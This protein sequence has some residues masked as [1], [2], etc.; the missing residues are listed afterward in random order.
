MSY[1]L[2]KYLCEYYLKYSVTDASPETSDIIYDIDIVLYERYEQR[3]YMHEGGWLGPPLPIYS[4]C[5][6]ASVSST[7]PLTAA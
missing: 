5:L 6:R 1:L 7:A 3:L 2:Y 4:E